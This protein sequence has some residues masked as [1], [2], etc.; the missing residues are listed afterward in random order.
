MKPR[1]DF[2]P[3]ELRSGA[4][5]FFV[6]SDNRAETLVPYSLQLMPSGADRLALRVENVADL[7]YLG[8]KVVGAHEMQWM[9]ALER[10]G[11]GEWGYR[12]LLGIC[13]LGMGRA[14]QH[15]LSNLARCVA[16]FDHLAGRQT[17]IEPYR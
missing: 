16:M 5:W 4:A 12:S 1:P 7:R 11:P 14:E 13:H 2:S 6:Q 15:R 17:D 9:M 10:L 8:L 3:A